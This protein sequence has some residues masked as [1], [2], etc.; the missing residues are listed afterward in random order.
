VHEMRLI[1]EEAELEIMR[2][3]AEITREAHADAGR[4]AREGHWEYELEAALA[5]AFRRRGASGPA[6]GSIV[7]GGDNATTL[8]YIRNDQPLRD[9]ELLLIDAG[10]ELEGYAS[11]VTRTY[12]VGGVYQGARRAIYELVLAAQEA[13]IA[14]CRPGTTL[15]E[16][17]ECAVRHIT[18]GLVELG[19]LSGGVDELIE[20]QGY[21]PFFTHGTSHWL[22]LDVHDC[23]IYSRSGVDRKLE[24]GMVF[25]IEPGIY[26]PQDGP[27]EVPDEYRGIGVR[28]EDN[29]AINAEGYENLTAAIPK[30][31]SEVEAAMREG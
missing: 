21:K 3:A 28:I 5:Y 18:V 17:H 29:I 14:L 11:D 9:G 27:E 30:Q 26:I 19:I 7:G 22:G 15:P 23:G 24:P 6:Y 2:R 13:A 25:T 10:A 1:K 12:P 20:K 4:L 8:H 16:L 31:P